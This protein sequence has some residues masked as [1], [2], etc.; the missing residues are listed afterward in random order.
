MEAVVA[1]QRRTRGVQETLGAVV[2]GTE[3]VVVF[4]G[5]LAAWGL[6]ALPA[7]LALGAGGVLIVLAILAIGTLR[8]PIGIVL[9]TIVQVVLVASGLILAELYIVGLIFLGL[10]AYCMIVGGR[11]DRRNAGAE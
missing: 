2:L 8:K 5:S 4:L 6:G 3:I 10:W 11:I 9:G 7:G 1:R